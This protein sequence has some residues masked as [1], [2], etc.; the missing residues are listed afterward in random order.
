LT[1]F[2]NTGNHYLSRNG[3]GD[4]E[5]TRTN[6]ATVTELL[7]TGAVVAIGA[8]VALTFARAYW[9]RRHAGH[10]RREETRCP[11]AV[12]ES[13]KPADLGRP[14]LDRPEPAPAILNDDELPQVG[15]SG[16]VAQEPVPPAQEAAIPEGEPEQER[17]P[18][19]ELPPDQ[20]IPAAFPQS[21]PSSESA[22][23]QPDETVHLAQE[24]VE[25]EQEVAKVGLQ[26]RPE[27]EPAPT[28]GNPRE[29]HNIE[30]LV[31]A[32]VS[33]GQ[34]V[35]GAIPQRGLEA[36]PASPSGGA[37]PPQIEEGVLTAQKFLSP[38]EEAIQETEP[39]QEPEPESETEPITDKDVEQEAPIPTERRRRAPQYRPPSRVAPTRSVQ[40]A[41][42]ADTSPTKPEPTAV[43]NH[44]ARI[45]LRILFDRGGHRCNVS[46][47]PTRP[48]GAPEECVLS[49][50]NGSIEL[51]ALEEN[52]YQDIVPAD[53]GSLLRAGFVWTED[54]AGMEWMLSGRDIFVFEKGT[55][56]RGFVS[57][58]RL[59]LGREHAVLCTTSR[60]HEVE[61]ILTEA[62]CGTWSHWGESEG[63][64][65]GWF[66]LGERDNGGHVRGLVP[67]NPLPPQG[68]DILDVLRPLP[69]IEIVLEEGIRLG[70][71]AWLVGEP[72]AIRVYGAPEST[73]T[74][75]IDGH[76]ASR[77]SYDAYTAPGWDEP[78]THQVWCGGITS[79]YSLVAG[80]TNS[81][82][83]VAHSFPSQGCSNGRIAI[84]GPLVRS[85]KDEDSLPNQTDSE[86][87]DLTPNNPVLLG[88]HP[89]EIVVAAPRRD[90]R[91]ARCVASPSFDPIW[92]LPTQPLHCDKELNRILL[93]G[94][95]VG[96]GT[97]LV[98]IGR[99]N[100]RA[101]QLWCGLIVEAGQK[102]LSVS[103]ET[104]AARELWNQYKRRARELRRT[105]G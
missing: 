101:I 103:P 32:H 98:H 7:I 24:A 63:A 50:A 65:Q 82:A 49:T 71:N 47:L 92:A 13:A 77:S 34:Q 70:Y 62:G 26:V 25:I 44:A 27:P 97:N 48:Q 58:A 52:W 93:V 56:H 36:E 28:N 68:S 15:A 4:L 83:W 21:E 102:G 80:E 89:G 14:A 30:P 1:N 41:Q 57:C 75:L 105:K 39:E 29:L 33:S 69:E 5:S 12:A 51:L 42:A 73:G 17:S 60:L 10:S 11:A 104:P 8:L 99:K 96:P 94:G 45:E 87:I 88:A 40:V 3:P 38:K 95:L 43:G 74:V 86:V 23:P 84:C 90:V 78:G 61:R 55:A 64:P 53:L 22:P 91:G 19:G 79:R 6:S 20:G 100:N 18:E 54:C 31:G 67:R 85:F 76:E 2:S 37:S 46:L 9:S 72:P 66:V 59:V 35:A 16:F 81:C